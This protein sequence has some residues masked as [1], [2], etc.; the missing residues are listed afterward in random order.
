MRSLVAEVIRIT[1][2]AESECEWAP[3]EEHVFFAS[4]QKP[5]PS[6]RNDC[7]VL[8]KENSLRVES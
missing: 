1:E 3:E 8:D 5:Q 6:P 7:K 4:P 2:E